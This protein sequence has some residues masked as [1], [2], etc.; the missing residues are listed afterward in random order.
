MNIFLEPIGTAFGSPLGQSIGIGDLVGTFLSAAIT[1][2]GIIMIFLFIGG[3]LMMVVSAGSGDSQGAAQGK[4]A[5]TWAIAG[6]I[7]VFT[8]YW[9]IKII[10]IITATPFLTNPTIFGS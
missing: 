10:E 8:A 2:S 5:V 7:I 1:V 3:G 9:I 6:F 4:Q